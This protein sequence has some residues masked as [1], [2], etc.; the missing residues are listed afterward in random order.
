MH[1][2]LHSATGTAVAG[3][4]GAV[5]ADVIMV[6]IKVMYLLV[7]LVK[8]IKEN[9]KGETYQGTRDN[10]RLESSIPILISHNRHPEHVGDD[11]CGPRVF[12][13]WWRKG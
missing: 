4:A 12:G 8:Q 13:G 2:G 9:E 7:K 5:V 10:L 1:Q 11:C 6:P 3:T